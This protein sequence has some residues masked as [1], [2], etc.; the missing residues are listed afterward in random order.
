MDIGEFDH[1]EFAEEEQ[2]TI[3]AEWEQE[4]EIVRDAAAQPR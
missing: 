2:L 3:P 4:E 1:E